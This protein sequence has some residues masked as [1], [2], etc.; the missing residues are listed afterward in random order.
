M[1]KHRTQLFLDPDQHAAVSRIANR[2]RR[3]I[4]AVVRD[5]IDRGLSGSRVETDRRLRALDDLA[6]LG[7]RIGPVVT[8]AIAEARTEREAHL[9]QVLRHPR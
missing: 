6:A 5:L 7:A 1:G 8:D 9:A 3:T 4:S 2:E